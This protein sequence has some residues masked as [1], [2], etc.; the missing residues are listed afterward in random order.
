[1]TNYIH[2]VQNLNMSATCLV[3]GKKC[4]KDPGT[5]SEDPHVCHECIRWCPDPECE[6][7]GGCGQPTDL[8]T[9]WNC[10]LNLNTKRSRSP[11]ASD[12]PLHNMAKRQLLHRVSKDTFLIEVSVITHI[13]SIKKIKRF[14][15]AHL[16]YCYIWYI[17]F[18]SII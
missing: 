10:G 4:P 13:I 1:M 18:F 14:I 15:T 5:S 8:W 11:S 17:L 12:S 2:R 6:R 9:C 7:V 16:P 3:C